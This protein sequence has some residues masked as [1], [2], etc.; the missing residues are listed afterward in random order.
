MTRR[1]GNPLGPIQGVGYVNELLARLT[2][3]PVCDNTTHNA[4]LEFPLGRAVYAD[5][6]HENL[7]IPVFA[8]LG[9]FNVSEPL[10]PR[11]LPDSWACPD[12]RTVHTA[13]ALP[14]VIRLANVAALPDPRRS[15]QSLHFSRNAPAARPTL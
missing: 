7:M 2:D 13:L 5:F 12:S 11:V 15:A 8:A 6:T 1:Y 14:R 4:S 9:L 10:D 3:S